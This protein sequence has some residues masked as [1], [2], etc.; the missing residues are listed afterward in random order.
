L[1]I[2]YVSGDFRKHTVSGFIECLLEHHDRNRVH[3]TCYSNAMQ[4]DEVTERMRQQADSWQMIAGLTDAKAADLIRSDE[5]DVLIDL[6]GHTA[7]NRLGIFARK[8][9][10]LQATLFGYPNTTGLQNLV[11]ITDS[12]ADPVGETESLQTESLLRLPDLAWVWKP[13]ADAPV[14]NALPSKTRRAFTFGC[15]NNPAKVSSACLESWARILKAVP[16]SR[17]VLLAGRSADGAR[18]L[19]DRFTQHGIATDRLELVYRLPQNEY[20]EAFQPIDLALDPFPYNGGV[21]TCDALWMGVPVLTVAGRDYRSRQ[22]LSLLNNVGLP[23]FVADS[24]EKLV[25]LASTW[26]DQRDGLADL[27]AS[28]REMMQASPITQA[29]N[30]VRNLESALR[31]EWIKATA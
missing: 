6:S 16:K 19:A 3:V 10:A 8:P 28:L 7:G 12:F 24:P 17:L 29:E 18:A 5:I 23:E 1:K 25:E 4:A 15:L 2:G 14:P 26:S 11:R 20:F 22:G 21:S 31:A 30:Y 9:A 27:R 13:P